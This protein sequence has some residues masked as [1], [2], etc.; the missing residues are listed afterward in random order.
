MIKKINRNSLNF[1]LCLHFSILIISICIVVLGLIYFGF[2]Y[3]F[4]HIFEDKI[5]DVSLENNKVSEVKDDWI[6]GVNANNIILVEAIHGEEVAKRI[7]E[8][9]KKQTQNTKTYKEEIDGKELMYS[10][11]ISEDNGE[12]I[13]TYSVIRNMYKEILPTIIIIIVGFTIFIIIISILGVSY[14]FKRLAKDIQSIS[15]Y[16]N[17][18]AYK[19]WEEPIDISMNSEEL[20]NLLH[21]IEYMRDKLR[22]IDSIQQSM[23]QYISHE[24]KT[25]IMI[26]NSYTEAIKENIYPCGNLNNS[27]DIVLEQTDRMKSKVDDLLF[28]TKLNNDEKCI[29]YVNLKLILDKVLA[30]FNMIFT[31]RKDLDIK[32]YIN[33]NINM[34]GD[35]K[36]LSVLFENIIDNQLRYAKNNI[37]IRFINYYNRVDILFF[38]DGEVMKIND[39]KDIFKPFVKGAKGKSGLGLSICKKIAEIHKGDICFI[40]TTYGCL[41]KVSIDKQL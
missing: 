36:K 20:T 38:N 24:L 4:N 14:N 28:I 16:T 29:N 33:S 5:I 27:L 1:K 18:I 40:P 41:F 34:I 7:Y 8:Q 15:R 13:Y 26:I 11:N 17:K 2:C 35:E 19:D 23:L 30:S 37:I 39:A 6:V 21:S 9:A 25:P 12:H 3:K 32:I 10:I 31:S 22:E